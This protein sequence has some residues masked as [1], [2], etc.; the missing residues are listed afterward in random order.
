[1]SYVIVTDSCANL[2]ESLF[3]QCDVTVIPLSFHVKGEEFKSYEKGKFTD[4]KQ[5]YDMMRQKEAITTS[6]I[7]PDTFKQFFKEI[8]SQGKD[9]L[10]IGFSSALSGTYQSS[11]IAADDLREEF[12]ERKLITVDS[13]SASFGQGLLVYYAAQLKAEGKSIEEVETWVTENR[14]RVC[15][16]FTCDD[17][18][19]LKR[20]GRVSASAA[21]LGS[22]LQVK[23]VMHVDNEGRLAVVTKARGRKQALQELVKRLE[24]N[25]EDPQKQLIIVGHGDCEDEA[26]YVMDLITNK[27][28][29]KDTL[30]HYLDP[31]IGAH[32][33]PGTLSVFYMGTERD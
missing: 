27:L 10:Y 5:F 21:V 29:V 25:I 8:L 22:L 12:P 28:S 20:G 23:P 13:L 1:M 32:A 19:F 11:V 9:V 24:K 6:L 18:F 15:H 31:V 30:I 33:G 7:G 4:L 3:E 14:L 17:L 2:P 16:W 26:K